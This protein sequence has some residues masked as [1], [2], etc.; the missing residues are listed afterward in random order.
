MENTLNIVSQSDRKLSE[1]AR[2]L[3][4][5]EPLYAWGGVHGFRGSLKPFVPSGPLGC[6]TATT[7]GPYMSSLMLF[8]R[9]RRRSGRWLSLQYVTNYALKG[10]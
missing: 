6:R 8:M 1:E 3:T 9:L 4:Q 5:L 10:T 2:F 7:R